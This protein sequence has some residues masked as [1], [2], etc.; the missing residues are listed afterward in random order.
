M[1]TPDAAT[2]YH[3]TREEREFSEDG[4]TMTLRFWKC[5]KYKCKICHNYFSDFVRDH[6]LI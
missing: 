6:S 3:T 1:Q 4:A 5:K 2:G